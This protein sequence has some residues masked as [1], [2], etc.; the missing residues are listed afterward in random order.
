MLSSLMPVLTN[1]ILSIYARAATHSGEPIPQL[2]F[3]ECTIRFCK[4]L[5]AINVA[6]GALTDDVLSHLIRGTPWKVSANLSLPRIRVLPTRKEIAGMLSRGFPGPLDQSGL[7]S[8][9][10]IM[11]LAGIASVFSAL[12]MQRK[13]AIVIKDFLA[14]LIPSILQAKMVGA[15]EAGVHPSAGITALARTRDL[16]S[17]DNERGLEDFLNLLCQVYGIPES[18]LSQSIGSDAAHDDEAPNGNTTSKVATHLP[19]QLIGNFVLRF[20]GSVNIKSDVLRACIH[21]CEVMPDYHGVLHYTSALLRTAGPG[22]APSAET[23]DVLVT[24][25][26]EEQIQLAN[27]ITKTVA[28]AKAAGFDNIEAEYW[29]EFLVRGC[30]LIEPSTSLMLRPHR[31]SD[32]GKVKALLTEKRDPF[33]HNPFLDKSSTKTLFDLLVAGEEREFVVALQNPYDFEVDIESLGLFVEGNDVVI[34]KHDLVLKPYRTQSFSISGVIIGRGPIFINGC[35]IKIKGCKERLFPIF[36]EPWSPAGDFKIKN[37]GLLKPTPPDSRHASDRSASPSGQEE[38]ERLFP[39]PAAIPLFVIPQQ[40]VLIVSKTSLPQNALMLLE[41]ERKIISVTLH[42]TSDSVSADFLHISLHDSLSSVMQEAL[43][44]K[45][46][47][48]ADMYEIEYQLANHPPIRQHIKQPTSIAPRSSEVFQFEVLGKPGLSSAVIQIDYANLSIPH[49]ENED[50][51]Y[52]RQVTVPLS[53]T[54]NSS[55]QVLYLDVKPLSG[56]FDWLKEKPNG[57]MHDST[58]PTD[59]HTS[60]LHSVFS[61][62]SADTSYEELCLVLLDLRNS[63][64]SPL[65]CGFQVQPV[66]S[67]LTQDSTSRSSDKPISNP[68]PLFVSD[69]LIQPGHVSRQVLLVPKIY[70]SHPHQRIK[71][72][73][74]AHERQF[75]VSTERI[76]H[77]AERASRESFWFREALLSLISGTWVQDDDGFQG[78][79]MIDL[80]GCRLSSRMVNALRLDELAISFNVTGPNTKQVGNTSFQV[81]VDDFVTVRTSLRNRSPNTIFPLLRLRPSL[82]DQPREIAL[83]L[84]KRFAWGGVLQRVLPALGPGEETTVDLVVCA[85]CSGEFEV[86]ASVEEIKAS[87]E[88]SKEA[89]NGGDKVQVLDELVTGLGRRVWTAKE[90]CKIIAIR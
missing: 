24:L 62:L 49:T 17:G 5:A 56:D 61:S 52:T 83:D 67:H 16:M 45:G 53:I 57:A 78:N 76:S 85:L 32:L 33:I 19:K 40:P 84:G 43:S 13:K 73:S 82:V 26:R 6:G 18:N 22:I 41:G 35:T 4:L 59:E 20:F 60:R 44:Q 29:D 7:S 80:R 42:N 12:G 72:I 8:V 70:L 77:E 75:V 10:N 55:I 86:G 9:D 15:A 3:S 2:A 65:R 63:W 54:V 38:W 11:I 28:D 90:G 30:I 50:S 74:P 66:P 37:I 36:S 47:A 23:S 88:P 64:P 58:R 48:P 46:V 27:S 71:P 87:E 69:D 21:L 1:M 51:C 79:G 14:A 31:R 68:S 81:A 89:E 39:I 25:S 34:S